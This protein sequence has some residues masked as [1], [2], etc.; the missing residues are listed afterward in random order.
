M[1]ADETTDSANENSKAKSEL[2]RLLEH[3]VLGFHTHFEATEVIGFKE[4]Q[5]PVNVFSIFVAEERGHSLLPSK[6]FLCDRIELRSLKGWKFG[7][8]RYHLTAAE[9]LDHIEALDTDGEWKPYGTPL[10]IGKLRRVGAQYI[11]ADGTAEVPWNNLLKNNFF[12]GSHVFEWFDEEKAA[13]I[14][15]LAEPR[16]LQ[17]LSTAIS[18]HVQLSIAA[19]SDRI[20][21]IVVQVPV[22]LITTRVGLRPDGLL[23]EIGWHPRAIRRILR[24]TSEFANEEA[25]AGFASANISGD[26]LLLPIETDLGQLRVHIWDDLHRVVVGALASSSFIRSI[27]MDMR[28]T[29]PEPRE[30]SIR[31]EDG[32][33]A[34]QRVLVSGASLPSI[35]GDRAGPP[36]QRWASRRLYQSDAARAR[37]ERRFVQYRAEPGK[38]KERRDQALGDIRFLINR[39]AKHGAWLWDPFLS[40][41]DILLTLFYCQFGAA[42][43]RALTDGMTLSGV[44]KTDFVEAQKATLASCKGNCE[45]LRLEY[46]VRIGPAGWA[47]HD[48]FLIFPQNDAGALAWSLGTSVNS[49]GTSHHILQQ[50]DDGQLIK[51]AFE[52]LWSEL[53]GTDHLVWKTP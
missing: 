31:G 6:R 32:Q 11:P 7:L 21:N 10:A 34:K 47:F 19:L 53:A 5:P 36:G 44:A 12:S 41:D 48:R 2:K 14:E 1:S 39:Y 20:G 45:R 17:E 4:R 26:E 40:A 18:P 49:A 23:I 13:L 9:L 22:T 30:F 50:V 38:E 8:V 29:S 15:L 27:H 51:D 24:I 37:N 25:V 52:D 43:L 33:L 16:R 28:P 42:D 3:G 35:I 46:R